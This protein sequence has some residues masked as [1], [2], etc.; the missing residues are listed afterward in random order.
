M[1]GNI[2]RAA[3]SLGVCIIISTVILF[4]GLLNFGKSIE[5]VG[6]SI[7]RAGSNAKASV[8]VPGNLILTTKGHL[9]IAP[10]ELNLDANP[11]DIDIRTNGESIKQP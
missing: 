4:F 1:E 6:K 2:V 3:R 5:R 7:E 9:Q 8:H 11:M 10:L